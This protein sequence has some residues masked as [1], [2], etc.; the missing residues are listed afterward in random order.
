MGVTASCVSTWSS[1]CGFVHSAG[2]E[3]ESHTGDFLDLSLTNEVEV[4]VLVA[5][6]Y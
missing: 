4:Q 5:T 3:L 1:E 2:F 6:K